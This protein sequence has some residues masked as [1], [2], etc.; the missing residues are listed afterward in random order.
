MDHGGINYRLAYS[1]CNPYSERRYRFIWKPWFGMTE[2][3]IWNIDPRCVVTNRYHYHRPLLK[4]PNRRRKPDWTGR[5]NGDPGYTEWVNAIVNDSGRGL[6]RFPTEVNSCRRTFY[7]HSMMASLKFKALEFNE[8]RNQ[9]F[10]HTLAIL[11]NRLVFSLTV[12]WRING[13]RLQ[14]HTGT[15]DTKVNSWNKYVEHKLLH[16]SY[17][18]A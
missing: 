15:C 4:W 12:E 14:I 11:I 5:I 10:N 6:Q 3:T 18:V 17:H 8:L 16:H 9:T 7:L 2:N 13:W 1:K